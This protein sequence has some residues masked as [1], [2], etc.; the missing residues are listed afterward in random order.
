VGLFV[1]IGLLVWASVLLPGIERL[2][3]GFDARGLPLEA[4]PAGQLI[5]LPVLSALL[6][7]AGWLAGLFFYRREDLRLLSLAMWASGLASSL[8]FLFAVFFLTTA[9]G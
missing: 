4:V 7:A 5:L 3:M 2:P 9:A 6:F 8:A 1:N